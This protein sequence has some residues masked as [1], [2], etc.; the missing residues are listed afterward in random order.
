MVTQVTD[1]RSNAADQIANAARVIRGS[2]I[3]R[4]VFSE[5]VRGKQKTKSVDEI[6]K[7]TRLSRKQIL[8]AGKYLADHHVVSQDKKGA[9]TAYQKV[10][11]FAQN[12]RKILSLATSPK[13]LASF[14][15]KSNPVITTVIKIA[16]PQR[17]VRTKRVSLDD[18]H[19]F[20]KVRRISEPKPPTRMLEDVFKEGVIKIVHEPGEF[21]DWG[22]EKGDLYTT[23]LTMRRRRLAAAFA[24]KGRGRS[25]RL[26]PARL[27][28]NGD[29]IQRLF[30]M[31]AEVFIVQYW[32]Q[33]DESVL[34]QMGTAAIAKSYS[35]G[36]QIYYGVIDGSDSSRLIAAYPSA[37]EVTTRDE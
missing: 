15:T 37:F 29:Q 8:T 3:R 23:R 6:A 30:T 27:G 24:F 1:T 22:G 5:V 10:P 21:K 14:P 4:K 16:V 35:T 7:E 32:D 9:D 2:R 26:T 17:Q 33:I 36:K 19:S 28:K 20:A 12:R 34:T 11:L 31:D 13:K 25:G 18:F